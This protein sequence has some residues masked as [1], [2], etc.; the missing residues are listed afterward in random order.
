MWFLETCDICG[1]G[2]KSKANLQLHV[3]THT[4]AQIPCEICG[5]K[6]RTKMRLKRHMRVHTGY[7]F[8]NLKKIKVLN[9]YNF[10]FIT[11]GATV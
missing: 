2:F 4:D 6:Y 9:V 5:K 10:L 8:L 3:L 11:Q 1:K 7:F